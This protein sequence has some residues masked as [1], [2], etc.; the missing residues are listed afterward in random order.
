LVLYLKT[1][2]KAQTFEVGLVTSLTSI[3]S[4]LAARVSKLGKATV[5]PSKGSS[6]KPLVVCG[7][8]VVLFIYV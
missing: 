6:M 3:K 1:S 7:C 8:V 4:D 5:F 2:L